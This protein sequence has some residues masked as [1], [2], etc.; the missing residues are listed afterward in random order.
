[1]RFFRRKRDHQKG[2]GERPLGGDTF[3]NA[4]WAARQQV[5]LTK[6]LEEQ[7]RANPEALLGDDSF[8]FMLTLS[9]T[10]GELPLPED[11]D[12]VRLLRRVCD[13]AVERAQDPL[14]AAWAEA[15]SRSGAITLSRLLG[16]LG[17]PLGG[18]ELDELHARRAISV[19][20]AF[21]A[22]LYLKA[23]RITTPSPSARAGI[24]AIDP[25]GGSLFDW[26]SHRAGD[27][28]EGG[29]PSNALVIA[30]WSHVQEVP[31]A[32]ADLASLVP[33]PLPVPAPALGDAGAILFVFSILTS[34]T[35]ADFAP[36]LD[37]LTDR[38]S[39]S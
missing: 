31:L 4:E 38:A 13:A 16:E 9:L 15:A 28:I 5:L 7:M 22:H 2:A 6:S 32:Q 18:S 29:W 25:L 10:K 1:M 30:L 33:R 23:R 3:Q 17:V 35:V 14:T 11:E 20:A 12:V 26:L 39:K 19:S 27:D 8:E 24:F 21:M 36:R 34:L 37:W